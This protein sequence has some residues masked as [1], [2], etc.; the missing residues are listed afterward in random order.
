MT[1]SATTPATTGSARKVTVQSASG[2]VEFGMIQLA[3]APLGSLGHREV[4]MGIGLPPGALWAKRMRLRPIAVTGVDTTTT[5][6][7]TTTR[8]RRAVYDQ[9]LEQERRAVGHLA[10]DADR[11]RGGTAGERRNK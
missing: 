3:L 6:S 9:P 8:Q 10:G 7:S 4:P 1:A 2:E 5:T 11:E